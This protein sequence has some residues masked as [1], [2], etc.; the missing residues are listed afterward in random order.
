L[1]CSRSWRNLLRRTKLVAVP[2][3]VSHE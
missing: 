2:W 3:F 1:Q